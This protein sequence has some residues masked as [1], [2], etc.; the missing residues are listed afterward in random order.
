[1]VPNNFNLGY[2]CINTELRKKD[3][4]TSRTL[5]LKTLEKMGIDYVKDMCIQN[6]KDLLE[7]LKWNKENYIYL[8]RMSSQIFP[9]ASHPKHTY[10]LDFADILLKEIGQY[11]K[12]NKIRLTLHPD[13]FNVLSSNNEKVVEQSILNLQHQADIMDRMQLDKNSIM[14]L[15]L[16][17]CYN[18]KNAAIARLIHNIKKLP[19]NIKDRLVLENCENCYC[20]EDALPVSEELQVPI[21]IDLHH[22][23]IYP[24]SKP[25]SFYYDRIFKV[26]KNRGIKPKVHVS[27]SVPGILDTDNKTKRRKHSDHIR[28]FHTELLKIKFPI[29]VMLECKL[30]E[31]SIMNLRNEKTIKNFF[32]K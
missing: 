7:I 16:G 20:L 28:F 12:D 8:Y 31:Q 25:A 23:S 15:H 22:D 26:W 24:S 32:K 13:Q 30:K 5:R 9:F 29:D 19:K 2:A 3:I 4:F 18:D 14:V 6:L 21:V 11:A 1:M 10:S 17:G 27:N